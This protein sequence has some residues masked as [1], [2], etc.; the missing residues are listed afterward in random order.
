[1][2][3]F[4]SLATLAFDCRRPDEFRE[5]LLD[6]LRVIQRGDLTPGEIRGPWAGEVG[7]FNSCR[8]STINMPWISTAMAGAI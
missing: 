4:R 5:Q 8:A 1:M 3:T 6:A 2:Q 7:Q